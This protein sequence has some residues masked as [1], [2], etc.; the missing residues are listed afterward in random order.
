MRVMREGRRVEI[1]ATASFFFYSGMQLTSLAAPYITVL[2]DP[3]VPTTALPSLFL[4]L[5][6]FSRLKYIKIEIPT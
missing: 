1:T 2:W 6:L 4:L 5:S 3:L